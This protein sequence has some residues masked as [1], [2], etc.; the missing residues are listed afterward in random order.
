MFLGYLSLTSS[1]RYSEK[2]TNTGTKIEKALS[3]S[4]QENGMLG[5]LRDAFRKQAPTEWLYGMMDAG[6]HYSGRENFERYIYNA[7][8]SGRTR[9][10]PDYEKLYLE[11]ILSKRTSVV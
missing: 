7:I 9:S 3:Q 6:Y 11:N 5:R 10:F 2:I 4:Q 1:E 8:A